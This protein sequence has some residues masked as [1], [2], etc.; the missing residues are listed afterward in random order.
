VTNLFEVAHACLACADPAEK[1]RLTLEAATRAANVRAW[2]L[3][4]SRSRVPIAGRPALPRLVH[5]RELAQRKAHDGRPAAR[6][7]WHAVAH[8]EFN[9]INLAWDAV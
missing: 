5:P 7:S 1:V 8:I 2:R 9:A 3:Y 4:R 6:R